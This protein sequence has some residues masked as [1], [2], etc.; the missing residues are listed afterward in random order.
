MTTNDHASSPF[1]AASLRSDYCSL[2]R[3]YEKAAIVG[4]RA[5][6][7]A[8]AIVYLAIFVTPSQSLADGDCDLG[9][10]PT[11]CSALLTGSE[12]PRSFLSRNLLPPLGLSDLNKKFRFSQIASVVLPLLEMYPLKDFYFIG[13]GR[14][15]FALVDMINLISPGT[16][17]TVPISYNEYIR[18]KPLFSM[19]TPWKRDLEPFSKSDNRVR[20]ALFSHLKRFIPSQEQLGNRQIVILDFANYGS[21]LAKFSADLS[22]FLKS[23]NRAGIHQLIFLSA[24]LHTDDWY[25]DNMARIILPE[26]EFNSI[27]GK[28][29]G[30]RIG[31]WEIHK[32]LEIDGT[33]RARLPKFQN[34]QLTGE[35]DKLG[36]LL[37]GEEFKPFAPYVHYVPDPSSR[38]YVEVL[39]PRREHDRFLQVMRSQFDHKYSGDPAFR[40]L[41]DRSRTQN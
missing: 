21:S 31:W 38:H 35:L 36:S 15:P 33:L 20:E 17:T 29:E 6:L 1:R 8:W 14:S 28:P 4:F 18:R 3:V 22:A 34:I 16:A 5:I 27:M 25:L 19:Y 12:I 9:K 7:T 24:K 39:T 11:K 32:R 41:V 40:G 30:T 23:E 13:I 26:D 2:G 10:E 37:D